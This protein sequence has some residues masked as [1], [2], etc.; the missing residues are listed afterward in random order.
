MLNID[1]DEPQQSKVYEKFNP[2]IH[3]SLMNG[4]PGSRTRS[5]RGRGA[6]LPEIVSIPFLKK[7]IHYA[8]T[9]IKPVLTE[10]AS[11]I[12]SE[13]YADLRSRNEG[14]DNKYKVCQNA[15]PVAFVIA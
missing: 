4:V 3:G 13:A 14:E 7:Y 8:K 1:D 12:I 11:D 15:N 10:E 5:R 6:G 9:R 2:L